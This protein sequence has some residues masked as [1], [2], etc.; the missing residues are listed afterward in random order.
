MDN[1]ASEIE[2]LAGEAK[3]CSRCGLSKSR[4]NVVFGKGNPS[5]G[6]LLVG[7]AP[8]YNEDMRGIPFCG[9][10]GDVLDILLSSVG[11]KREDVYITNIIKCRPPQN[12]DPEPVEIESC[13]EYLEKQIELIRP[14]IIGCLGRH[15]LRYFMDR[16]SFNVRGT[17]TTLHGKVFE[18]SEDMFDRTKVVALYHPAVAVYDPGKID[19]LKNDF[20]IFAEI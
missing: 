1:K 17:I 11:M 18:H 16:F 12:R 3:S 4:H 8:G 9:K 2:S 6:I 10:A 19:M 14:R 20:R 7:E 15:S 13:R 5:S